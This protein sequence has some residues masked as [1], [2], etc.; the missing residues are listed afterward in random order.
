MDV[1]NETDGL[2]QLCQSKAY[3]SRIATKAG[4]I[5][6]TN[7]PRTYV[8]PTNVF[9]PNPYIQMGQHFL[10]ETQTLDATRFTSP[11]NYSVMPQDWE[12]SMPWS[13]NKQEALPP[14]W[15]TTH[16]KS[17]FPSIAPRDYYDTAA[18]NMFG[19]ACTESGTNRVNSLQAPIDMTAPFSPQGF[20]CC[21]QFTR[22]GTVNPLSPDLYVDWGRS[23][24]VYYC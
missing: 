8:T 20:D 21:E 15:D 4:S 16:P 23:Q 3:S 22:Y 7:Y 10:P 17:N 24:P 18:I 12:S 2:L 5:G 9:Q 1:P 14:D 11:T 13:S 19:H 6:K